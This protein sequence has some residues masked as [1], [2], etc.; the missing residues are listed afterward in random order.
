ME[1]N[2]PLSK[3][4]LISK[5]IHFGD[6]IKVLLSQEGVRQSDLARMLGLSPQ[7]V[8]ITLGKG[9]MNTDTWQD[10]L[11]ILG[12]SHER[13]FDIKDQSLRTQLEELTVEIDQIKLRL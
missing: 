5:R 10:I 13:F 1:E 9:S 11:N 6:R 3:E 7:S 2:S 12:I 8:N 4:D